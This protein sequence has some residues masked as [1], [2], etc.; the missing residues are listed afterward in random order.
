MSRYV[1][2]AMVMLVV[3]ACALRE[4]PTCYKVVQVEPHEANAQFL[5]VTPCL[6][7]QEG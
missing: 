6:P 5:A 3:A 1:A 4:Q 2:V 7:E